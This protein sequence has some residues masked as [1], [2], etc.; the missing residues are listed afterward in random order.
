MRSRLLPLFF[1][2]Y[3]IIYGCP[4]PAVGPEATY[5]YAPS[6]APLTLLLFI[7]ADAIRLLITVI[8]FI[9]IFY[10]GVSECNLI[11]ELKPEN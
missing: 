7:L 6:P 3:L 2:G 9:D 5:C 4:L 8:F 1:N 11:Y 10:S